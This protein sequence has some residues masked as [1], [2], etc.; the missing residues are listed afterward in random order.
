MK[1]LKLEKLQ[2]EITRE[3][4]NDEKFI[5]AALQAIKDL[6]IKSYKKYQVSSN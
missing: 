3:L 4:V 1:K 6:K 5:E 2:K